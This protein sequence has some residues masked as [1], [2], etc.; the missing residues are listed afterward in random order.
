MN[1]RLQAILLFSYVSV[2][3]PVYGVV[4]KE[5]LRE[6]T[7]EK[8]G[9]EWIGSTN[10]ARVETEILSKRIKSLTDSASPSKSK[11]IFQRLRTLRDRALGSEN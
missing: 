3:S 4:T 10:D 8:V 7:P 9:E 1:H 5:S 11:E 2:A 6:P